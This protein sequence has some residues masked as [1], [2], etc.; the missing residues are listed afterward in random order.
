MLFGK[1]VAIT[2][3]VIFY[4]ILVLSAYLT[5]YYN[6]IAAI[7]GAIFSEF[8]LL[9]AALLFI[10]KIVSFIARIAFD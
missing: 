4:Q 9:I 1:I 6:Q 8:L 5:T 3:Y 2:F 10:G 7:F